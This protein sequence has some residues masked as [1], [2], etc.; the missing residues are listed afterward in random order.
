[1]SFLEN[2]PLAGLFA[3]GI[4]QVAYIAVVSGLPV[5]AVIDWASAPL[6]RRIDPILGT[7]S[8][9]YGNFIGDF[10]FLS[11]AMVFISRFYQETRVSEGWITASWLWIFPAVMGALTPI[12]LIWGENRRGAYQGTADKWN[13]NRLY[14]TAYMAF[15]AYILF[16]AGL[17]ALAFWTYSGGEHHA[18]AAFACF[19]GWCTTIYM[20]RTD[21]PNPL[22][23]ISTQRGYSGRLAVR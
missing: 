15:M 5:F 23:A 4:V 9:W 1:M 22:L 18:I 14:H 3:F 8:H 6:D 11:A 19:I 2:E 10:F 17:R 16:G 20:D 7:W 12:V 21:Y 13:P